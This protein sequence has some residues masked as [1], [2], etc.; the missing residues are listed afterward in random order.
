MVSEA[1]KELITLANVLCGGL[2]FLVLLAYL[3][4]SRQRQ[5]VVALVLLLVTFLCVANGFVAYFLL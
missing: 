5:W 4:F 1:T 2:I 3:A